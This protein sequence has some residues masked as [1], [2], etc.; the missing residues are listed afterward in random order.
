MRGKRPLGGFVVVTKTTAQHLPKKRGSG[1]QQPD[2]YQARNSSR[3]DR[4]ISGSIRN[5]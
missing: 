1:D 5:E 4:G 3:A 2:R